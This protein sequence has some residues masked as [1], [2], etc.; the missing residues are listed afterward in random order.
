MEKSN[1]TTNKGGIS[2]INKNGTIL[3]KPKTINKKNETKQNLNTNLNNKTKTDKVDE[4]KFKGKGV[5]MFD[6][7][8]NTLNNIEDLYKNLG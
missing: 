3:E 2:S 7:A 8:K 1:K 4:D 5:N 6:D